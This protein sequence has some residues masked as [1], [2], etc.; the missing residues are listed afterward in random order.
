MSA[1]VALTRRGILGSALALAAAPR[2]LWAQDAAPGSHGVTLGEPTPFS[3]ETVVEAARALAAQ[4]YAPPPEISQD[5]RGLSYD[6][7]REIWFESLNALY[8]GT[9]SPFAAEMFVASLYQTTEVSINAVEDGQARPVN[10]ELRLFATTD[11]FPSLPESG[12]GFSGFRLT[13]QLEEPGKYQEFAV[14]QGASYFRGIG[15]GQTYGISARGIALRTG[16]AEGAEEFPI[17]RSF[18]IERAAPGAPEAVV[19]AL[20][21]G[22]SVTGAYTFRI[23]EEASTE[24]VV[25]AVLFPRVAL[26]EVG[27]AAQT[28]MFLFNDLNRMRFDDFREGVHDSDGLLVANGAGEHLWR[29]LMNPV[30]GVELSSFSDVN[31]RGFG[32]MQR[33]RDPAAYGDFEAFYEQRPSLW[34]EP[35][36]DWGPGRVMLVEIAADKEIYDNIVCFWRPEAPLEAG[37]ETRFSYRLYW[38]EGAPPVEGE[39]ARVQAT[40]TGE[41]VFEEGRIFTI[42]YEPHPALGDDP[43]MLEARFTASAGEMR[44]VDVKQNPATGGVRLAATLI[45]PEDRPTELRAELWRGGVRVGEVWLYRWVPR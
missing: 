23:T 37:A 31:P 3:R 27:L 4:P 17:F 1:S 33:A 34:V 12:T 6:Q 5:W 14:W 8:R 19:H 21:D 25:E 36:E 44:H 20:L 42:D 15:R 35:L 45:L 40:R 13:H 38:G 30:E 16:S 22:P 41:R 2:A 39:V 32:L 9:D 26:D 10:F 28:S 18:W 24:M 29:P 7:S 43:S 11:R